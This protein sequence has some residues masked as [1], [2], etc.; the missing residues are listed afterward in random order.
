MGFP[1]V[2][3]EGDYPICY[4]IALIFRGSANFASLEAFAKLILETPPTERRER[5]QAA[6]SERVK[7]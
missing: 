2:D 7:F 5:P 3:G 6:P 1:D 4:R